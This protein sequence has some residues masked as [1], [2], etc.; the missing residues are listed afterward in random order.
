MTEQKRWRINKWEM[1]GLWQLVFLACL[2]L[3]SASALASGSIQPVPAERIDYNAPD[4]LVVTDNTTDGVI[5]FLVN[6]ESSNWVKALLNSGNMTQVLIMVEVEPP[7]GATQVKMQGGNSPDGDLLYILDHQEDSAMMQLTDGGSNSWPYVFGQNVADYSVSSSILT[8][9]PGL[10]DYRMFLRWYDDQGVEKGTEKLNIKVDFTNISSFYAIM[11]WVPKNEIIPNSDGLT[12]VSAE[13][14]NGKVVYTIQ[15]IGSPTVQWRD[16]FT[17]I[18]APPEAEECYYMSL[19]GGNNYLLVDSGYVELGVPYIENYN[20]QTAPR[21]LDFSLLWLDDGGNVIGFGA[22]SIRIENEEQ[23]EPWPSYVPG[24]NPV[25]PNR[26]HMAQ[27]IENSGVDVSY[28]NGKLQLEYSGSLPDV[29]QMDM[30][31]LSISVTPPDGARSYKLHGSSGFSL[32]VPT[33]QLNEM[34]TYLGNQQVT[35]LSTGMDAGP[36]Q[37]DL[38]RESVTED[39]LK[40]YFSSDVGTLEN[41]MVYVFQWYS[42]TLGN[43]L[44]PAEYYYLSIDEFVHIA[45]TDA[46]TSESQIP[47]NITE[48]VIVGHPNW[49]LVIEHYPQV[50][51]NARHYELYVVDENG[52]R[53]TSLGNVIIYLPYPPGYSFR[54]LAAYA[55]K[56]YDLGFSQYTNVKIEPTAKGLRFTTSS[57]SPFVVSWGARGPVSSVPKTGDFFPVEMLIAAIVLLLSTAGVVLWIGEKKKKRSV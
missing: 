35:V 13:K 14:D 48:P 29:S 32:G 7:A 5:E 51:D 33:G 56:H 17:K 47:G 55:L 10:S 45:T 2:C 4:G 42:D 38:F 9:W 25:P 50:G 24:W 46:F 6:S 44:L 52:T 15:P 49:K 20:Y 12:D 53:V 34:A 11:P 3:F 31:K 37:T 23:M 22:I 36:I 41:G 16:I 57:L 43:D 8:P 1:I 39:G 27:H 40:V 28:V 26:L 21:Q 30:A 19:Y 18:K 54:S